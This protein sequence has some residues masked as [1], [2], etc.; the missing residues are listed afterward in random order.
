MRLTTQAEVD[1]FDCTTVES[2]TVNAFGSSDPITDLKSLCSL[3]TVKK[4]LTINGGPQ[5]TSL[6]GLHGLKT[7]G[8]NFSVDGPGIKNFEGVTALTSV[9]SLTISD[10]ELESFRGL[11][12][13]AGDQ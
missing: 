12:R 7:V 10:A 11:D 5:L 6:V 8:G 13:V 1:A 2:L 4:N 3:V 9:G